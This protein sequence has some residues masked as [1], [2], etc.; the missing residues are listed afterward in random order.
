MR[1]R[2]LWE[3]RTKNPHLRGLEKDYAA[4][5]TKFNSLAV[6]EMTP[7]RKR[8]E[9]AALTSGERKLLEKLRGSV[10]VLLDP[11]GSEWTSQEFAEWIGKQA[12]R[13][14]REIAFLVGDTEGF[15]AAFRDEAD[16]LLS[17][18]RMTLTHE[19]ARSLL[20]E[21]I[22]RAFTILRGFPY[23]R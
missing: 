2:I 23:A 11:R 20:L 10:K 7:V 15:S 17:V 3:G 12:V 9:A 22:Y 6:E 13:G 4:R 16:L 21:Q 8:C 14:T 1:I 18:S 19:W 5:I